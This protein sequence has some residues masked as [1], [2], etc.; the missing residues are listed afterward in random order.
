MG[1]VVVTK[2]AWKKVSPESQAKVMEIAEDIFARLN[3]SSREENRAAIDDIRAA[4]IEIVPVPDEAIARFQE[5]GARAAEAGVGELY[6][7]EML[8]RVQGIIA[9]HR[10]SQAVEAGS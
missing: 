3:A 10:E 1:A 9:K 4:G 7:A 8:E 6:T 5:I 2:K